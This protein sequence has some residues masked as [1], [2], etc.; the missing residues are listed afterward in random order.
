MTARPA[1]GGPYWVWTVRAVALVVLCLG[2]LSAMSAVCPRGVGMDE[3]RE[4]VR[5]GR[6]DVVHVVYVSPAE[7]QARWS[8]GLLGD[9]AVTYRFEELGGGV[10]EEFIALA[11][12]ELGPAGEG[13]AFDDVD[14]LAGLGGLSVLAP[15]LYWRFIEPGLLQWAVLAAFLGVL[16][17]AC[18]RGSLRSVNAG[19]WLVACVLTGSGAQAYLWSEP[20]SPRHPGNPAAATRIS[21]LGVA[22]RT[23]LWSGA[24]LLGGWAVLRGLPWGR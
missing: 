24:T 12:T 15:V 10:E 23:L 16:V 22:A 17:D 3:L 4:D 9:K 20:A 18:F 8:V 11:R 6:V 14:P 7:V 13:V 2:C 19:Y 1:V 5:G 21:G